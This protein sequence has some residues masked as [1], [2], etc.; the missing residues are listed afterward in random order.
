[1][2]SPAP[3][4]TELGDVA[5]HPEFPVGDYRAEGRLVQ[6]RKILGW[7]VG[8]ALA[9]VCAGAVGFIWSGLDSGP[10]RRARQG[11]RVTVAASFS[12]LLSG[13]EATGSPLYVPAAKAFI[14]PIPA[15]LVSSAVKAYDPVVQLGVAAGLVAFSQACPY[16][17]IQLL[18]CAS[19]AWFECLGCG[20]QFTMFGEKRGG[21]APR[22]MS[23]IALIESGKGIVI[24]TE[25]TAPGLR[26]GVDFSHQQAAGPHCF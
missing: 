19:S 17:G 13:V 25:R 2:D 12:D 7:A 5:P 21:P 10:A 6:R 14:T 3:P 15:G 8:G 1:M 18:F 4:K 20:S 23:L 9:A 11:M 22:G 24:D 26:I 16:D